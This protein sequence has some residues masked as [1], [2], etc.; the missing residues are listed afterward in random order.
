MDDQAHRQ[1]HEAVDLTHPLAVALGQVIVYGDNVDALSGQSVQIGGQSGHQGLALAGFHLGD[2]ALMQDD[3]ADELH[4]IGPHLQHAPGCLA[5]G[6]E[7]L[8]QNVV[9]RLAI[10]K[11]LFKLRG[12]GLELGVG[13]GFILVL[14]CL[15]FGYKGHNGLDL[16]LGAGSK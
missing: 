11:T 10:G 2:T 1:T 6:G 9:Q 7:G 5:A 15:N 8:R 14:Q 4:P 13:K 16:P 12:L 3:A